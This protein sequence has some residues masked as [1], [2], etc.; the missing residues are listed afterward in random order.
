MSNRN[1]IMNKEDASSVEKSL[2]L[3]K[4]R[5][6]SFVPVS[7]DGLSEGTSEAVYNLEVEDMHEYFANGI[8]VHNCVWAFTE[9]FGLQEPEALPSGTRPLAVNLNRRFGGL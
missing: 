6:N 1:D 7:V 8:L 3:K 4:A 9:L 2:Q 5:H